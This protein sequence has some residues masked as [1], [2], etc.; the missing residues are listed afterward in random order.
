MKKNKWLAAL[1]NFLMPGLGQLYA[2]KPKQA[3][4]SFLLAF[5]VALTLRLVAFNFPL[6]V[7]SIC[8]I[9]I[10]FI[11][12]LISGYR[13]VEENK[14]YQSRSYDR[15][16][17]Y[18]LALIFYGAI[19]AFVIG[20]VFDKIMPISYASIPTPAMAPALQIGDRMAFRNTK[21]IERNDVAIFWFTFPGQD[22]ATMYVKRCIA[23]PGDSISVKAGNVFVNGVQRSEGSLKKEYRVKTDASSINPKALE[24][25]GLSEHDFLMR[26]P[27]ELSFFLTD[28]EANSLK[29]LPLVKEISLE[30]AVEGQ[31]SDKMW[32]PS[33]LKWNVDFYGPLYIPKKGDKI[34]VT[35]DRLAIYLRCIEHENESVSNDESGLR[36][37]GQLIKTYEFK[38][39]YYFMMGDNRHNSLDSR[40]W[41]LLPESDVI[42][43]AMYVY[44]GAS[45]DRMGAKL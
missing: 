10:V 21:S 1:L 22:H 29:Q 31:S 7:V 37:N 38:E 6:F 25:L 13:S 24:R 26:G 16:Y 39:N 11:W 40:Y 8:L 45:T 18:F 30:Q 17:L 23:L 15:V 33:Q 42:G 43:K 20:P 2:Q 5:G 35:S 19:M 4:I 36:V 14:E 12:I 41:G 28:D 44:W 3:I 27:G 32:P 34:D 9:L